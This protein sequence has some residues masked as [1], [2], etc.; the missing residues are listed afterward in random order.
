VL[1]FGGNRL[2]MSGYR[3]YK[4][5]VNKSSSRHPRHALGMLL[6]L[7]SWGILHVGSLGLHLEGVLCF[8]IFF[9]K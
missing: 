2:E 8:M 1:K 3:I 6:F 4:K 7:M 5:S 9:L